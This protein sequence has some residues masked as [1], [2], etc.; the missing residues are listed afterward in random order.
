M[1]EPASETHEEWKRKLPLLRLSGTRRVV[2]LNLLI[3]GSAALIYARYVH[4]LVPLRTEFS[5]PW[6]AM[7][8]LFYL[9]EIMVVHLKFKRDAYSFSLAEIPLILGLFFA[10]PQA[11]V[12]GQLLGALLALGL[13]RRQSLLKLVFNTSHYVLEVCVACLIFFALV[14]R[15]DA[16]GL[17]GWVAAIAASFAASYLSV[18]MVAVAISLSEGSLRLDTLPKGLTYATVATSTTSCLALLGA[19]VMWFRPEAAVLLVVPAALLFVAYRAYLDQLD[20]RESVEF[21]YEST[22]M[23]QSHLEVDAAVGALLRQARDMFRAEVAQVVLFGEEEPL[24]AHRTALG[25]GHTEG[26]M[27]EVTLDPRDGIWARVASEGRAVLLAR[28]I[29]NERL[30]QH[31]AEQGVAKDAMV[32]PLFAGE[33][34][35]GTLMVGDRLGDVSTFDPEDLK[36]FETLANHA[37]VSLDNARLVG[38]LRESLAHL[39]EMNRLKDDFV[40]AVSHELRTPLTSIQGYVKTLLRPDVDFSDEQRQS[41]LEA[42]DRQSSRLRSLIEDLLVVSRLEGQVLPPVS[43]RAAIGDVVETVVTEL[44]HRSE[45]RRVEL[46]LAADLPVVETDAGKVHQIVSN[47]LE[48]AFKYSPEGTPVE[49]EARR[50][51]D[52][53]TVSVV[54]HGE[55]VPL[56]ARDRIFDRFYQVDQSSTRPAGGTGLGLYICKRLAESLGARVWLERTGPTGST[57]SLWLPLVAPS[58]VSRPA[59]R[60]VN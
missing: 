23:T 30:K 40:A 10:S 35:I 42:V 1:A 33:K 31:F 36:L 55:G 32:A 43:E 25:A 22:R 47:L 5:I 21:L 28:P 39:T 34:V 18:L 48:N 17:L 54:D 12:L 60:A 50:E 16:L 45:G 37:S 44:G 26:V 2:L 58:V 53:V 19:T 20:K 14:P 24:V 56:E 49:V 15:A 13:N 52:G 8:V 59:S 9:D 4:D 27:E 7:V 6:W 11:L 46:D 57:F 3:V 51:G 29:L 41:F 38:R